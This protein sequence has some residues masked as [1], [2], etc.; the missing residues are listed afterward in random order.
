M[1]K[2]G[3]HV[4]IPK[5][6]GVEGFDDVFLKSIKKRI[7]TRGHHDPNYCESMAAAFNTAQP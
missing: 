3:G 2:R 5:S 4:K 1:A 7:N 6:G